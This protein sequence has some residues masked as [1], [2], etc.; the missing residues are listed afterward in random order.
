MTRY[1]RIV[2]ALLLMAQYNIRTVIYRDALDDLPDGLYWDA[3][4]IANELGEDDAR[5]LFDAPSLKLRIPFS[6]LDL[7]WQYEHALRF[8]TEE[9]AME[10]AHPS[11]PNGHTLYC[12]RGCNQL[13]TTAGYDECGAC[14]ALMTPMNEDQYY[15]GLCA[16]GQCM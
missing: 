12:P 1:Q 6:D 8:K 10:Q 11:N 7:A 5:A 13:H 4:A 9:L 14:G 15:D 3:R 2:E 16:A